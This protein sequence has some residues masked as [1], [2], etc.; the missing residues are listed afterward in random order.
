MNAQ[1]GRALFDIRDFGALG[2]GVHKDSPAIQ[3]AIDACAAD[4]GAADSGGAVYCPPGTYLCGT[5]TLK[6]HVNLHLEAGATLLGSP[7]P[8]DYT[9]L[10]PDPSWIN[11][12]NFDQ[13]LIRARGAQ[14]VS[15]SGQGAITPDSVSA[16]AV[17]SR[18]SS[19]IGRPKPLNDLD[20]V[21][22]SGLMPDFSKLKKLPVRPLPTWISSTISRISKS[23]QIFS[24]SRSHSSPATRMPPSP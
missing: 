23:R 4:S 24:T 2:D 16:A 18:M 14:N 22:I 6:S 15:I 5:I 21:T 8:A 19:F 13:H 20:S 17:T 12:F 11:R 9:P 3:R 10:Y 1:S 7:E